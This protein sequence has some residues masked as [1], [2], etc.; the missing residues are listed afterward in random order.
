M[1][2][3]LPIA[4]FSLF[5]GSSSWRSCRALVLARNFF[6]AGDHTPHGRAARKF[7]EGKSPDLERESGGSKGPK[8]IKFQLPKGPAPSPK[9]PR[10]HGSVRQGNSSRKP[11]RGDAPLL[12]RLRDERDR[13]AR[14]AG[15]EGRAEAGAPA[16]AL[17]DARGE[18]RLAPHL[19][20]AR[21][22]ERRGPRAIP[23][24]RRRRHLLCPGAHGAGLLAAP[25]AD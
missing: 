12:P 3:A 24:A 2:A 9:K 13:G 15:R 11:G 7:P 18:Q 19:R 22:R 14:A 16:R 23:S 1:T 10:S 6:D 25:S 17:R 20:D 5:K 21:P 4:S 8:L